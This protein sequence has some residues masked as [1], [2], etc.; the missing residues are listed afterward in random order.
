M[1]LVELSALRAW[2]LGAGRE[3]RMERHAYDGVLTLWLVGWLGLPASLVLGHPGLA[4]G[5]VALSWLP[6][7]YVG[8]RR[9]LHQRGRLRCDWLGV[10]GPR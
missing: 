1:K 4:G 2:H 8:W 6:R 9:R 10:L 3:A 5:C 7:A